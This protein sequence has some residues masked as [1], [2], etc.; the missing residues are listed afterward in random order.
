L[1]GLFWLILRI[2]FREFVFRRLFWSVWFCIFI[3]GS[4]IDVVGDGFGGG[5]LKS[6]LYTSL[7]SWDPDYGVERVVL[8]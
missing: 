6:L 2:S 1:V 8:P 5:L 7:Y 4:G 3:L